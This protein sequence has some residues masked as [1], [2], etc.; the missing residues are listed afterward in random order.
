MKR[1]LIGSVVLVVLL[2]FLSSSAGSAKWWILGSV[3][4]NAAKSKV[5]TLKLVRKNAPDSQ[6]VSV[7]SSNKFGQYAFSN[8]G[9]G[10]P[11][12]AYRLVVYIGFDR[13]MDVS[14]AG[15]RPGGRVQPITINY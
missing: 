12:S 8:P 4:G 2:F 5:V 10:L 9:E 14:L 13:L 11:P 1:T 3:K 7:T 15:V 6:V